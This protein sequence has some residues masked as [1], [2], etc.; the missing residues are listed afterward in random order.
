MQISVKLINM[1]ERHF[2]VLFIL[3]IDSVNLIFYFK[4][5]INHHQN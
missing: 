4:G 2:D 1:C 3:F 5:I